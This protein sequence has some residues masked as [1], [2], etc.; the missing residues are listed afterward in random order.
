MIRIEGLT[1]YY[2]GATQPS[3]QDINLEVNGGEFVLV[4]GPSGGGKSSLCR[5][6]N[7]LIPHFYGGKIAGRVEVG[8]LDTLK[9]STRELATRVGMVFQ[10]PENQLVSLDVE[11]E[12]AFGLENLAFPKE[13]IA[14]R[15]E[16]SLDTL[17]I[18]DLRY[19]H[20][21]ELSGGEKQKVAIASVLA[22]HP[23]ILILDEPTSELDPKGAEEV[24]SVVTR[25]NDELGL[26]VILVEHRL[27]RVLQ[28][29]DRLIAFNQ[30]RITVDGK[31]RDIM[32]SC[33]QELLQMGVGV[34]PMIRLVQGLRDRGISIDGTPLTVKEGR[35]MLDKALHGVSGQ[36]TRSSEGN[37][38]KPLVETTRLWYAYPDGLTALKDIS[39]SIG[40]GEFVAII[41]RNASGKTTLVKHFN[42]LLT[43]TKGRVKIDGIDTR[44]ATIAELAKK[45]GFVFQNPNDHLFADTVNDEITFTLKNL[46]FDSSEIESRTSEVLAKFNLIEYRNHY[47]RSLSGGEKQRVA[48]ASVLALNPKIL[49][50]DEP[51]RGMEYRL[52]SEL[53]CFLEEYRQQ[54]NTVILVSHDVEMVAEYADR[55][56][57]LSEGK[58]VVDGEKHDVLSQA[59][60]FSPQ[61]NR[62]AQAFTGYGVPNNILTVDEVLG[63]LS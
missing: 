37:N 44:G 22:L 53:M 20:L 32:G 61:I 6:L 43:P 7:G 18:S 4:T 46:G 58:I 60:L 5:C 40:A 57:L 38:S 15:I 19:R 11:R 16:E 21:H 24:L 14:K 2:S 36:F 10:D 52:K 17:G 63:M 8:G 28:Y 49:I 30:G 1:F 39:L 13:L 25:L 48:L 23:S 27:D 26:T 59:L 34:P 56:I 33:Y 29:A 3:L 62:L 31:V 51:T 50:L 35:A 41:G 9:H 54:G 12:I 45:V 47:P 42:H 55:V